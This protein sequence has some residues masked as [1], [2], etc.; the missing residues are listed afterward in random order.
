VETIF[1][2]VEACPIDLRKVVIQNMI[3]CGGTVLLPGFI[4]RLAQEIMAFCAKRGGS[5]FCGAEEGNANA[6]NT[7]DA[8]GNSKDRLKTRFEK[9]VEILHSHAA[10]KHPVSVL[11]ETGVKTAT[12]GGSGAGSFTTKTSSTAAS[13][14]SNNLS[15]T[16]S[17]NK[18]FDL[19]LLEKE[20]P[21]L[22]RL[23]DLNKL[24]PPVLR[25]LRNYVTGYTTSLGMPEAMR[26]EIETDSDDGHMDVE[27]GEAER[28]TRKKKEAQDEDKDGRGGANRSNNNKNN[29]INNKNTKV[30]QAD[31]EE[32]QIE[33]L[34]RKLKFTFNLEEGA[35]GQNTGGGVFGGLFGS[36]DAAM[37]DTEDEC[38]D[39]DIGGNSSGD[40]DDEN[41]NG[42]DESGQGNKN[43][44]TTRTH[45]NT[46]HLALKIFKVERDLPTRASAGVSDDS[47]FPEKYARSYFERDFCPMFAKIGCSPLLRVWM[48][49]SLFGGLD[50]LPDYTLA[51]YKRGEKI[52][53][54]M[55]E[56][57]L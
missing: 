11:S 23:C 50:G 20:F 30:T 18:S 2:V 1:E 46:D 25:K 28:K 52:R 16:L 55:N 29:S 32:R 36:G 43:K 12:A 49:A 33:D 22:K 53:E 27:G 9:D 35:S 39:G 34:V 37:S 5:A 3:V 21:F 57:H 38:D 45:S 24:S 15:N 8:D 56:V 48:G 42:R 19:L 41:G 7:N 54:W 40:A 14:S 4:P 17:T 26:L 10:I 6:N 47:N 31:L 13:G 51:M 44:P